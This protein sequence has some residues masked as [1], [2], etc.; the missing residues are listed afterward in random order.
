MVR[1]VAGGRVEFAVASDESRDAASS[2]FWSLAGRPGAVRQRLE[3]RLKSRIEQIDRVC[4]LTP[5][6]RSKLNVAG[7]GDIK[8]AFARADELKAKYA[9]GRP[10]TT[11]GGS[12]WMDYRRVSPGDRPSSIVLETARC[13]RRFCRRRSPPEQTAIREKSIR[14][15]VER[16]ASFRRSAG[17][18]AAWTS[19]AAALEPSSAR[20]SRS[21]LD[22]ADAA[23]LEDSANTTITA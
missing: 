14:E 2:T 16:P 17:L 21:L 23:R 13:F 19:L 5:D 15:A 1:D 22:R 6:Q 7:R 10:G 9:A 3:S 12:F 4:K 18:S 8:R 20:S 11:A